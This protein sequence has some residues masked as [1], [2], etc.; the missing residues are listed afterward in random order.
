M[1]FSFLVLNQ[2]FVSKVN[3]KRGIFFIKSTQIKVN[4]KSILLILILKNNLI[5]GFS[6]KEKSVSNLTFVLKK[7][8]KGQSVWLLENCP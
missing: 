4:D 1:L 3:I 7:K 2:N 8:T 6:H 5:I